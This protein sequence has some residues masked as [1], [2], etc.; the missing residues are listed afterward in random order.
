MGL[1]YLDADPVPRAGLWSV[2]DGAGGIALVAAGVLVL[3]LKK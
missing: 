1:K 2:L 3:A